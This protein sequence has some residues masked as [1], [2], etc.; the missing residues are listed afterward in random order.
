MRFPPPKEKF[1]PEKGIRV[2][3]GLSFRQFSEGKAW[4][5]G[6]AGETVL[7]DCDA[8]YQEET[9]SATLSMPAAAAKGVNLAA[10]TDQRL[11]G[12]RAV[13]KSLQG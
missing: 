5:T 10:E 8:F 9:G 11:R 1:L 6:Q 3:G 13:L 2:I 7:L 12:D 4:F